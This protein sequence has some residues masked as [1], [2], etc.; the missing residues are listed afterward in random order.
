VRPL[1][2]GLPDV[3]VI[4][5]RSH[6]EQDWVLA[7]ELDRDLT[8]KHIFIT[9][10][11]DWAS[12]YVVPA[13]R[14]LSGL[15]VP[16]SCQTLTPVPTQPHRLTRVAPNILDVSIESPPSA[17]TFT[18]SVYRPE[19]AGFRVGDIVR[20]PLYAVEILETHELDPTSMRFYFPASLDDPRFVF[21]HPM[22]GGMK[23]LTLP[24]VGESVR[25]ERPFAP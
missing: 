7:A 11:H 17:A 25:L 6:I 21:L 1:A 13:V 23:R 3:H 20:T 2:R 9:S 10:A 15:G 18:A 8:G 24:A 12:M 14:H 22:R 5:D 19:T 16:A 4:A